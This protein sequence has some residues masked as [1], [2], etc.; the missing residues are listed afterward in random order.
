MTTRQQ[1]F[2]RLSSLEEAIELIYKKIPPKPVGVEEIPLENALNRVLAENVYSPISYP[3][4][5]RSIVDGYAV[6][7]NDVV[8]AWEDHPIKLQVKG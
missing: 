3:P 8:K 4:Y 1:L 5:P 7:A 6:R 2:I